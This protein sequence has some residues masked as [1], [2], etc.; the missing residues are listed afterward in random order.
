MYERAC[1]FKRYDYKEVRRT[2][3][4]CLFYVRIELTAGEGLFWELYPAQVISVANCV[5]A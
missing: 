3:Q 5:Y 4:T 1:R 2:R